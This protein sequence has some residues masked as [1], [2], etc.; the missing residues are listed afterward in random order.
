MIEAH[1]NVPVHIINLDR[2]AER[3]KT[4][5]HRNDFLQVVRPDAVEG[6]NL[7]RD[8]LARTGMIH[9]DLRYTIQPWAMHTPISVSGPR[10]RTRM[11]V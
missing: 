8:E 1:R 2:D 10:Q 5:M 4:F 3:L 6:R 7:D 11:S 9:R